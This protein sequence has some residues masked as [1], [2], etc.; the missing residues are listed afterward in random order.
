MRRHLAAAIV[1]GAAALAPTVIEDAYLLDSLVLI[2]MWGAVSAAWNVA[3]GYA[4]Q[5]SLG[6]AAFFGLGAYSAALFAT[7]WELSPWIGLLVGAV[8]STGAGLVIGYLSNRLRGPYF[9]LATIAFAQ[10]LQI[11]ASRWRGF[12]RGSEG[13]P[14]PFRPGFWTLGFANKA[15]WVYLTLG[16][17]LLIYLVEVYLEVS[18]MGYRLAGVREDEDAAQ[19][20]G[21]ASRRLK[22]VAIAISAALTSVCGSFWAQYVGF[23][24]PAYVFSIDLSILFA[25]NTIIGGLGTALGPFY[26]SVLITSLETFLRA[27]FSGLAAGLSSMY[28]IIYGC[29]LIVVVRFVPQG[30]AL[31]LGQLLRRRIGVARA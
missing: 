29:L 4:G 18:R 19:A 25:L 10:V 20:V 17:A 1:F 11:V 28:L 31:W 6:H 27:K 26:G 22:V 21:I 12:T 24:D 8:L 3:G 5:L 14:V 7:R 16:V 9:A 23:V 30:L 15:T 13:I 2:L